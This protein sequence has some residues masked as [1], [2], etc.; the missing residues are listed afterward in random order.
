MIADVGRIVARA[1]GPCSEGSLT[2]PPADTS[3]FNPAT[4]VMLMGLELKMSCP[5]AT[6]ALGSVG[7][8][9][10]QGIEDVEDRRIE[11][12]SPR[13]MSPPGGSN[14]AAGS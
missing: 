1:I 6:A 13:A 5:R 10:R 8:R 11:P 7:R 9:L 14:P 12:I 3:L 4:P 2:R